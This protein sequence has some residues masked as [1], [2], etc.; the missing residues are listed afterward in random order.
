MGEEKGRRHSD[1][2]CSSCGDTNR[3]SDG[4]RG[5]GGTLCA[6]CGGATTTS[7]SASTDGVATMS[8]VAAFLALALEDSVGQW[9][10]NHSRIEAWV[11]AWSANTT[12]QEWR[13]RRASRRESLWPGW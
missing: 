5:E 3:V 9:G 13:D 6:S 10:T 1:D 8:E 2:P 4:E 7:P 12:D 11:N